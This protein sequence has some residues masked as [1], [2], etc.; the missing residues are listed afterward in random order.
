MPNDIFTGI[1]RKAFSIR[2]KLDVLRQYLYDEKC[3]G[4]KTKEYRECT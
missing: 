3:A 4:E 1:E 2:D